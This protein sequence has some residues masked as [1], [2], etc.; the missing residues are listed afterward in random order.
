MGERPTPQ[1]DLEEPVTYVELRHHEHA[2]PFWSRDEGLFEDF[3]D[4]EPYGMSR[5]T[6]D[7]CLIWNEGPE[8]AQEKQR[9]LSLLRQELHGV[10]VGFG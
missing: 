5:S 6:F 4:W 2:G 9:L 10:E 1:T 7:A 3:E 8:N